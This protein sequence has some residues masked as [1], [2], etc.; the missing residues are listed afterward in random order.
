MRTLI[1]EALLSVLRGF[2]KRHLFPGLGLVVRI[3][4]DAI[5][6]NSLDTIHLVDEYFINSIKDARVYDSIWKA[7]TIFVFFCSKG[8]TCQVFEPR[9]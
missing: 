2:I 9:L 5:E 4:G 1:G 8:P 6:G 7:F 3:L